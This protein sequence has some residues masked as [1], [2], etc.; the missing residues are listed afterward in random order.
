MIRCKNMGWDERNDLL[1]LFTIRLPKVKVSIRY[2]HT[3]TYLILRYLTLP[4]LLY[5]C[6]DSFESLK[7]E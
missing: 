2:L 4:Y 1:I 3:L 5:I 6:G 7:Y